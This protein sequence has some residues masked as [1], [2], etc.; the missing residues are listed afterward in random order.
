LCTDV[1][2]TAADVVWGLPPMSL[3]DEKKIPSLGCQTLE[4]VTQFLHQIVMPTSGAS[5]KSM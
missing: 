2:Q 5:L 4:D 3:T 1:L